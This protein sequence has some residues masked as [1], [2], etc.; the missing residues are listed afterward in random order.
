MSFESC[1]EAMCSEGG[2][3]AKFFSRGRVY[4]LFLT[5]NAA[6]LNVG[7]RKSTLRI[8]LLR[9][10][11][12]PQIQGL[13]PFPGKSN[14]FIGKHP[15]NWRNNVTNYA[16]VRYQNVY[17]GV[18]LVYYGNTSSEAGVTIAVR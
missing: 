10:N 5:S 1:F 16:R 7:S 9:S 8:K 12:N 18:D 11:S 13:D 2:S 14:Y 4:D 6:V 15:K 17:P 3:Q